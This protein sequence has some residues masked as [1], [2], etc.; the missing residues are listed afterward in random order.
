MDYQ[1]NDGIHCRIQLMLTLDTLEKLAD[2]DNRSFMNLPDDAIIVDIHD[3]VSIPLDSV[4]RPCTD[5]H[6][7]LFYEGNDNRVHNFTT[8]VGKSQ[9]LHQKLH[10]A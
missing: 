4:V 1:E 9:M 7:S 8:K 5:N 2:G 10:L 6:T 3:T